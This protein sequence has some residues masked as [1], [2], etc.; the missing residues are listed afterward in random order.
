MGDSQERR[1]M[2]CVVVLLSLIRVGEI[3]RRVWELIHPFSPL[4]TGFVF[5]FLV[6]SFCSGCRGDSQERRS[7]V[8]TLVLPSLNR[9]IL[10]RVIL[11]VLLWLRCW[12]DSHGEEFY[13]NSRSPT[14]D[15]FYVHFNGV[16]FSHFFV[17]F[18]WHQICYDPRLGGGIHSSPRAYIV[19]IY[20]L[21]HFLTTKGAL[22]DGDWG[23]SKND[24]FSPKWPKK[25][26]KNQ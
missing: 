3:H 1:V 13:F 14:M 11:F 15:R 10:V 25:W 5:L 24:Q 6:Y 17:S 12:G 18:Y 21:G 2:L 19:Y 9:S 23:G 22:I 26:S 16:N 8:L 7:N 4:W 20:S